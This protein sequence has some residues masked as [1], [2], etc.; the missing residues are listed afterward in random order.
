MPGESKGW[1]Q[2]IREYLKERHSRKND[3]E[4]GW[5]QEKYKGEQEIEKM[6]LENEEKKLR[7]LKRS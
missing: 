2:N 4:F 5:N 3:K 1:P 6:K 7:F